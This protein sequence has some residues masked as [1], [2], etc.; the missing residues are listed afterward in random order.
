ML[1]FV[2]GEDL[3]CQK[4]NSSAIN[5]GVVKHGCSFIERLAF[6]RFLPIKPFY[7]VLCPI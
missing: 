5:R 6:L 2:K 7:R 4:K 1:L 3:Y